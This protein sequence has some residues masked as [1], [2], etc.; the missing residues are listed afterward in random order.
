MGVGLDIGSKTIKIV[1]LVK[2]GNSIKLKGSGVVGYNGTTP[3]KFKEGKDLANLAQVVKKLHKEAKISS[4][5][6]SIALPEAKVFTRVI[7]FPLL[8]DQEIASAIKWEAEQYIPIPIKEAIVQH[9]IISRNEEGTSPGVRVLL[10]AASRNLVEIYTKLLRSAGLDVVQVETELLALNRALAP[11]DK[12]VLI[13]DFGATSTDIAICDKG[14]LSFSRSIPTAGEA[15]TRAVSQGLNISAQQAEE[16]KKAYGL[17]SA[18]LEGKIRGALDPVFRLVA[19]EIKKAI[20]FFQTE[21]KGETPTSVILSGGTSGM[22]EAVSNLSKLLGL[23]IV[24]GNPF[25]KV[26]L[27]PQVAKMVSPYAPLYSI[28]VGVA[29]G[30][31]L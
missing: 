5:N 26:S 16:Y 13:I 9:Q 10:V 2:E 1:E 7:R 22:P 15:F 3:D 27:S 28:S 12:V 21:E 19:D 8:T 25:A 6:I 29:L 14:V 31:L 20:H 11:V 24:V 30:D 17:S 4:K 23:E 18:K